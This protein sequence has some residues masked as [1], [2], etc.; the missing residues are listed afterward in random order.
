MIFQQLEVLILFIVLAGLFLLGAGLIQLFLRKRAQSGMSRKITDVLAKEKAHAKDLN[1]FE[2]K[3]KL[4]RVSHESNK[5]IASLESQIHALKQ[6]M[7]IL[8][9]AQVKELKSTQNLLEKV[10]QEKM[11]LE[12]QIEA[13][14]MQ[15]KALSS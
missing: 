4:Q 7:K 8:N 5:K 2:L 11:D 9:V 14:N 12:K 10:E 3:K 1:I 6:Q 15:L 13:L